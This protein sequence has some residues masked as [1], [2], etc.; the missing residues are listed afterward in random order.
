MQELFTA[1]AREAF[2]VTT[3]N[4]LG[5]RSFLGFMFHLTWDLRNENCVY[6]GSSQG[7]DVRYTSAVTGT[8]IEGEYTDY[9]V[10]G[11]FSTDFEFNVFSRTEFSCPSV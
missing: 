1:F 8:V 3:P 10:S 2:K 5:S 4:S 7:G 11:A 6:A 9:V